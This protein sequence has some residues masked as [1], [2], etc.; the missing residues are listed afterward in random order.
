V[1]LFLIASL[2]AAVVFCVAEAVPTQVA[3]VPSLFWLG[4]AVA[5]YLADQVFAGAIVARRP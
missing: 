5:L 4:L 3:G 2:V 1:R